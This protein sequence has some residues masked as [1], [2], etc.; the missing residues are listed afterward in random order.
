MPGLHF[1]DLRHE[2][3]CRWLENGVP[4]HHVQEL[5]GHT[6][7]AQPSTCLHAS[8]FGLRDSIHR[9]DV[10]RGTFVAQTAVIDHPPVC[11]DEAIDTDKPK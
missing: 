9:Y 4:L 10:S 5:L 8:E 1:H 11:H 7:L 6:N 3:G 2:A